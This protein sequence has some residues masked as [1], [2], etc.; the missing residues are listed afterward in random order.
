MQLGIRMGGGTDMPIDPLNPFCS[1]E[2]MVDRKTITGKVLGKEHSITLDEAVRLWTRG[3][4]DCEGWGSMI[5][6]IEVGKKADFAVLSQ[7][8]FQVPVGEIHNTVA[9]QTWVDG[10]CVYRRG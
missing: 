2:W 9:V 10:K 1:I 4:A 8:I 3:S 5:G 7:D 6:S